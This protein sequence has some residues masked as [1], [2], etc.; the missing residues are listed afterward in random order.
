MPGRPPRRRGRGCR[1]RAAPESSASTMRS[2]PFARRAVALD[3]STA[4]WMRTARANRPKSRSTRWKL[5]W[6]RSA[7]SERSFSPTTST[8]PFLMSTRRLSAV[9]PGTSTT[10]STARSVSKR[11]SSGEHSPATS[12]RRSGRR[13]ASS[14]KRRPTSSASSWASPDEGIEENDDI[15]FILPRAAPRMALAPWQSVP[16]CLPGCRQRFSAR[17]S[18]MFRL[19]SHVRVVSCSPPHCSRRQP[20]W[21]RRLQPAVKK[22]VAPKTPVDDGADD[23][24]LATA[25]RATARRA[26]AMARP[27]RPSRNRRLTSANWP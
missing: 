14:S 27:P 16:A 19:R 3:A 22:T 15:G 5:A 12:G 18:P 11:S 7:G 23:V 17:G 4:A 10:T 9:I 1:G 21:P 13:C 25:P 24:Q 2:S 26:R 8:R 20:R 6:R